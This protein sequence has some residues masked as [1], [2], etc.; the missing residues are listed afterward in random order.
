MLVQREDF[1]NTIIMVVTILFFNLA[2]L[3]YIFEFQI[4]MLQFV[5]M[6]YA[7]HMHT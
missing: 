2:I 4:Y 7:M 1:R 5:H 6:D 3:Y